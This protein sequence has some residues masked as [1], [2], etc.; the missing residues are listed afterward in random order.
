M[1]LFFPYNIV[2]ASPQRLNPNVTLPSL[3]Y[4][5]SL[6]TKITFKCHSSL[7]KKYY[8]HLDKDYIQMSFFPPYNVLC[9]YLQ[10]LHQNITFH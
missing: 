9:A 5:M 6:F 2:C 8:V 7:P 10:E 3:K 4:T 1:S